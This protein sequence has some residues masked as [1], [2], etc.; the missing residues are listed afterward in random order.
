M[1]GSYT[2]DFSG[3]ARG[4]VCLL[5]RSDRGPFFILKFVLAS[6]TVGM[7]LLRGTPVAA[8]MNLC[9]AA[10]C[11]YKLHGF[12][13]GSSYCWYEVRFHAQLCYHHHYHHHCLL[14][15]LPSPSITF[16]IRRPF[17][18]ALFFPRRIP[19]VALTFRSA[20]RCACLE[21]KIR[22]RL[23]DAS[24]TMQIAVLNYDL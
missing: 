2:F 17:C 1:R 9:D 13:V 12:M 21:Q 14:L 6:A 5:R 10:W 4:S 23:E 22:R 11:S 3:P 19:S 16:T 7:R 20:M 15:P 18:T 8:S 24:A